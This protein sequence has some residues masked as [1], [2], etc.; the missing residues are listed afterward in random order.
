VTPAQLARIRRIV[1]LR[2]AQLRVAEANHARDG[3]QWEIAHAAE[4]NA[5][6][7]VDAAADAAAQTR[8]PGLGVDDLM[9]A[10]MRVAFLSNVAAQ[11]AKEAL[12]AESKRQASRKRLQASNVTS[13]QMKTWFDGAATELREHD[14]KR[15]DQLRDELAARLVARK[16]SR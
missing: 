11:R 15:D 16:V 5:E 14:D 10:R 8:G 4:A 13:E 2:G 3:A 6:A 1:M 7:A 12:V 9:E